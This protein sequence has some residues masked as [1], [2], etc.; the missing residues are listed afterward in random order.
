VIRGIAQV[1]LL[2]HLLAGGPRA[3]RPAK[4]VHL[5]IVGRLGTAR[6]RGIARAVQEAGIGDDDGGLMS[7][8]GRAP[9][10]TRIGTACA[11]ERTAFERFK[12]MIERRAVEILHG[13]EPCS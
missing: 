13:V 10:T 4:V 5:S 11:E 2:L 12:T 6:G 1:N 3:P 9:I 7:R 8:G